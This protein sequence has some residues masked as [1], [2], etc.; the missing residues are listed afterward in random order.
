M[1]VLDVGCFDERMFARL[2]DRLGYGV[3]IDPMLSEPVARSRFR[4]LRASFP[5]DAPDERFDVIT[6]LAVLEHVQPAE[7]TYWIDAC[8]SLLVPGGRI[9][10]SIPAPAVDRIV[11]VLL[12]LRVLHGMDFEQHHGADPS[13]TVESF[14]DRGFTLLRWQRF[15]AGLNNLIVLQVPA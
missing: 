7:L 12:K 5:D 1:R 4:L 14:T 2:G 8:L 3:G 9:V 11:D 15:Q 6:M 13:K 10:A